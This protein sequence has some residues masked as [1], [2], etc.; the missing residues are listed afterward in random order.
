[1]GAVKAGEATR[2]V[3]EGLALTALAHT[4][5]T[6]LPRLAKLGSR[7]LAR[8]QPVLSLAPWGA[9]GGGKVPHVAEPTGGEEAM[10]GSPARGGGN[11]GLQALSPVNLR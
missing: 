4:P 6:L 9:D 1:V 7:F 11:L 3:A 2:S 8:A 5:A 10:P